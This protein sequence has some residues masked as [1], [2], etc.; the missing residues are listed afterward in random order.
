MKSEK[1]HKID[2]CLGDDHHG[3]RR[4]LLEGIVSK[5]VHT[6]DDAE[7]FIKCTLLSSKLGYCECAARLEHALDQLVCMFYVDCRDF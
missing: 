7:R 2:S 3:L 1:S 6:H 4:P 5:V